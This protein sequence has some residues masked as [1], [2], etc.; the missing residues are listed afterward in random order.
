[1]LNEGQLTPRP[2]GTGAYFAEGRSC[3][4]CLL[5]AAPLRKGQARSAL[6][7]ALRGLAGG[8]AGV[9]TL[10]VAGALALAERETEPPASPRP[11][12]DYLD[13]FVPPGWPGS[14]SARP[15]PRVAE[16]MARFEAHARRLGVGTMCNEIS[17]ADWGG[18][19]ASAATGG[20][21]RETC[22]A[23]ADAAVADLGEMLPG[24]G[25]P[26]DANKASSGKKVRK[27]KES[28]DPEAAL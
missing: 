16:F 21:R 4:E 10:M 9:C 23:L 6:V 2:S 12:S 17:G 27:A 14:D 22:I 25:R 5:L 28:A 11:G 1:M 24:I 13:V 8:K 3:G 18:G 19:K 20:Y 15:P 7:R 26:T